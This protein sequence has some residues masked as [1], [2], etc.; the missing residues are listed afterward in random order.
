M[1][2]LQFLGRQETENDVT[3]SFFWEDTPETMEPLPVHFFF[4]GEGAGDENDVTVSIFL[5]GQE[6]ERI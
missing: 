1:E 3:V 5:F 2:L 4:E 6:R